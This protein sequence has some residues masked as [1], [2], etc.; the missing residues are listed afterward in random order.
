MGAPC[1]APPAAAV[2]A[3]LGRMHN[4]FSKWLPSALPAPSSKKTCKHSELWAQELGKTL[5]MRVMFLSCLG[6][7]L[8]T[9]LKNG[10]YRWL[11]VFCVVLGYPRDTQ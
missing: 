10:I 3:P 4:S 5:D 7:T 11:L 6:V 8:I 9:F 1:H 2:R